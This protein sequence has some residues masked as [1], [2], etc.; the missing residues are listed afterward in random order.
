MTGRAFP[1]LHTLLCRV[2]IHA[3]EHGDVLLVDLNPAAQGRQRR[4][5]L[6]PSAHLE[7]GP[8]LGVV[9]HDSGPGDE[10]A[11][12]AVA[13]AD[14]VGDLDGLEVEAVDVGA[15]AGPGARHGGQGEGAGGGVGAGDEGCRGCFPEQDDGEGNQDSER[16]GG[17]V[18]W[19][20]GEPGSW[21]GGLGCV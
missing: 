21:E 4:L 13:C 7:L 11:G 9:E 6:H 20:D 1:L 2:A 5:V 8:L 18:S 12:G 16:H 19:V 15:A 3:A 14:L 17:L 10:V